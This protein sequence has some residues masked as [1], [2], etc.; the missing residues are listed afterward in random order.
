MDSKQEKLWGEF[1]DTP[2]AREETRVFV[3]CFPLATK[4]QG[5]PLVKLEEA[6]GTGEN[7]DRTRIDSTP[8]KQVIS[9][10]KVT[11]HIIGP[12]PVKKVTVRV[13]GPKLQVNKQ[14]NPVPMCARHSKS[15]K[16]RAATFVLLASDRVACAISKMQRLEID[17]ID[18]PD[19][20]NQLAVV[21]YITDLYNF[22]KQQQHVRRPIDYMEKQVEINVQLRATAI[23]W[24]IAAHFKLGLSRETLYLAVYIIDRYLTL[25]YVPKRLLLLVCN[26]ALLIASKYEEDE[27][28]KNVDDFMEV[29]CFQHTEESIIRMEKAI[30][31]KLEWYLTVP[32]AFM[33][34][35]RFVK[36]A[37]ANK[38]LENMIYFYGELG[39]ME[40]TLIRYCPCM[41][42]A[43]AVYA[44]NCTL[45]KSPLWTDTLQ[46]HSSYS[47][48]DLLE[49]A[50]ILLNAHLAALD[51]THDFNV[52]YEKYGH[53]EFGCVAL[54]RPAVDLIEEPKSGTFA[55]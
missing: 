52:L 48:S 21:E 9:N 24:T 41:V 33:F 34:L 22:Y 20:N 2:P 29:L 50:R 46:R 8:H 6:E 3:P 45:R 5:D 19:V 49:C 27:L 30:L 28:Q 47:E 32:T 35:V 53:E 38:K 54:Y 4:K 17:E 1:V 51:D 12:R 23:K 25:E 44:A 16:R 40:Y 18:L 43:A 15:N 7:N 39:L 11:L 26:S 36:A 31:N 42:A 14:N 10:K 37:K 55:T 13:L